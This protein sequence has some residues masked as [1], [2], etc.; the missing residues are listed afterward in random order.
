MST[1]RNLEL[2][3]Q[4][5]PMDLA[6]YYGGT[7]GTLK[8]HNFF[9]TWKNG[10][11]V[12]MGKW[13]ARDFFTDLVARRQDDFYEQ[14]YI[15]KQRPVSVRSGTTQKMVNIHWLSGKYQQYPF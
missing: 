7:T 10:K 12:E 3:I 1:K 2:H 15:N 8:S 6:V 14:W 11:A 9:D 5:H 13:E 4:K